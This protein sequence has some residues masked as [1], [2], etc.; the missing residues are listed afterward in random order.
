[1]HGAK[2]DWPI[3]M[4]NCSKNQ[5]NFCGYSCDSPIRGKFLFVQNNDNRGDTDCQIQR[6]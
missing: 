4:N 6:Y 1:M 5:W 3:W 2:F